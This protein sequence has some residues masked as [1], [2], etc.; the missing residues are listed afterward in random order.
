MISIV[1]LDCSSYNVG[2]QNCTNCETDVALSD[3]PHQHTVSD[4]VIYLPDVFSS[5]NELLILT[6]F[7]VL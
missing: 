7:D 6:T 3:S 4:L 2:I 1:L 5:K